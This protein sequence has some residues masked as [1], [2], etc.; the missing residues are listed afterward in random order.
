M[1]MSDTD[2]TEELSRLRKINASLAA[3]VLLA[4]RWQYWL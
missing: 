2:P 4:G 1:D 3:Y